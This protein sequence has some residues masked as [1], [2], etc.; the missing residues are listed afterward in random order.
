MESVVEEIEILYG[1]Y[2]I[3]YIFFQDE[4]FVASKKR[5]IEFHDELKRKRLLGLIKWGGDSRVDVIDKEMLEILKSTNVQFLDYG[6]ESMDDNVLTLM[7]KKVTANDNWKCAELTR[8][9]GIPFNMNIL[10]GMPGDTVDSI[11]KNKLFIDEFNSHSFLRTIRPPTPYPGCEL[12]DLAVKEG[13]LKG[14]A[15]FFDKF[16]NSDRLT[17][18]FTDIP[19]EK[20][21]MHLYQVNAD[22]V[23]KYYEHNRMMLTRKFFNVYF[24]DEVTFRGARHYA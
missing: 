10:W 13:K 18:N 3:N 16:T 19:D 4:M 6:F 22:L 5:M 15:D 9:A 17:V 1:K 23:R 7:K 21:Y 2:G 20:F 24:N 8:Q 14:P 12:Y 11:K